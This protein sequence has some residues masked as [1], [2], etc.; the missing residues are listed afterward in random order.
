VG[1]KK[2]VVA[3][4]RKFK[5]GG[6]L[7]LALVISAVILLVFAGGSMIYAI[8]HVHHSADHDTHLETNFTPSYL[9]LWYD[10]GRAPA[11]PLAYTRCW[12]QQA[13]GGGGPWGWMQVTDGDTLC[14]SFP[15][16]LTGNKTFVSE[17]RW[18]QS[19]ETV[20]AWCWDKYSQYPIGCSGVQEGPEGE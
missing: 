18:D 15:L 8:T 9:G 16:I 20:E 7:A 14:Q 10:G 12:V 2:T 5:G 3:E 13:G 19:G 1:K 11:G 6:K 4:L 17:V